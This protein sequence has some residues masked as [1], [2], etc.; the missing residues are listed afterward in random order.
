MTA[1]E[2]NEFGQPAR[3]QAATDASAH[4]GTQRL[5]DSAERLKQDAGEMWDGA[6]ESARTRLNERKDAAAQGLHDVADALRGAADKPGQHG[7]AAGISKLS[8]SA[9]ERLDSLSSSLRDKDVGSLLRDMNS[10]AHRQ[11]L[12]FFGLALAAGFATTR[13]LKASQDGAADGSE[14]ARHTTAP[15]APSANSH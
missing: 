5:D 2:H 9:A 4:G 10:F 3:D 8:A 12:A 1:S 14:H 15:A 13:F 7:D 6:R 11:P